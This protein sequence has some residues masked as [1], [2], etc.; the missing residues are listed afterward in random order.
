MSTRAGVLTQE[1][2]VPANAPSLRDGRMNGGRLATVSCPQNVPSCAAGS[3]PPALISAQVGGPTPQPTRQSDVS[4]SGDTDR[5]Q[6]SQSAGA[7]DPALQPPQD[8]LPEADAIPEAASSALNDAWN[9]SVP[10]PGS[11]NSR[12]IFLKA[13]FVW[14][15]WS[16]EEWLERFTFVRKE[17]E[18][19]VYNY[20]RLLNVESR[21]VYSPRMVGT[22]PS[23][24]RPSVIVTCRDVDF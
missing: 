20:L 22:C 7:S 5:S 19:L 16:Q 4:A 15:Q 13:P 24:A 8:P 12:R 11:K 2:L 14:G 21:P 18:A 10:V 17:L 9:Y 1:T 6:G 3:S 23:D